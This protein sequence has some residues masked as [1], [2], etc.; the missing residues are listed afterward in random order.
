MPVVSLQIGGRGTHKANANASPQESSY[1]FFLFF[2]NIKKT[3]ISDYEPLTR[4]ESL[5]TQLHE[6][7][8]GLEQRRLFKHQ[9]PGESNQPRRS[10]GA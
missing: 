2:S 4:L 10:R 5:R 7:G 3:T 6:A 1:P 8:A 9:G